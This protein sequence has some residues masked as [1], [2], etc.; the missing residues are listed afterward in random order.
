M[1][2]LFRLLHEQVITVGSNNEYLEGGHKQ[3][4]KESR[5]VGTNQG[6]LFHIKYKQED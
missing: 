5:S 2:L 3:D 4:S 6:I 1:P